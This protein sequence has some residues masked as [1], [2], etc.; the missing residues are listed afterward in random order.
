MMGSMLALSP[1]IF[2]F[3]PT[4]NL[5]PMLISVRWSVALIKMNKNIGENIILKG[6]LLSKMTFVKSFKYCHGILQHKMT[7]KYLQVLWN[8]QKA[9]FALGTGHML[10]LGY[11]DQYRN[12][13]RATNVTFYFFGTKPTIASNLAWMQWDILASK[14]SKSR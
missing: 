3:P 7:Q 14:I 10:W 1:F 11:V 5:R 13:W 8:K 4:K 2:Q 12:K 6:Q 9:V